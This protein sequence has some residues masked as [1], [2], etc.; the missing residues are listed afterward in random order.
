MSK[1]QLATLVFLVALAVRLLYVF[2]VPYGPLET[3]AKDYDTLGL[4]VAQGK[5]LVTASGELT[6]NRPPVYPLF[7][8][9]IY[10]AVGHDLTWVRTVQAVLSAYTCVL[11]YLIAA[12]LFD[13]LVA[14]LS[15]LFCALYLPFIVGSGAILTETLFIFLCLAFI[16]LIIHRQDSFSTVIAGA[17]FGVALLTRPV[18]LF[19]LPFVLYWLTTSRK[20]FTLSLIVT[21]LTGLLLII[22]P[23][24]IRNYLQLESFV[25]LTNL[26]GLALYNS[27]VVPQQGL[28]YNSLESLDREYFDIKNETGRNRYLIRKTFDYVYQN[29]M[30]VIR[31]MFVKL[32]L[33]IYPFDGYWYPVSFG[34]RYNIFWG[35]TLCFGAASLCINLKSF[36]GR[37]KLILYLLLSFVIASMCFYGSPRFRLPA[38]PFLICLAAHGTVV[39]YKRS[40]VAFLSILL[41]NLLLFLVFRYLSFQSVFSYCNGLMRS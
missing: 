12:I 19:F 10:W 14:A 11:T 35:I 13:S 23:W 21:F 16:V 1:R 38:E 8:G 18:A 20:E 29:P 40:R 41:V 34:S 33:L 36:D 24:T 26:G 22:T 32:A 28:G 25:P 39:L 30:R 27:Y 6:A 31:F 3:D 7:L 37:Q 4:R 2:T 9:A 5:G 17:V 15:G